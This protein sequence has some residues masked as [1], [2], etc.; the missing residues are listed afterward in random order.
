MIVKCFRPTAKLPEGYKFYVLNRGYNSGRPSYGPNPNCFVIITNTDQ[1]RIEL[2]WA[3]KALY[4][5]GVFK[6]LLVGS[7]IEL[8][9]IKDFTQALTAAHQKL[10]ASKKP[11]LDAVRKVEAIQAYRQHQEETAKKVVAL[12]SSM[13][14][15]IY[16]KS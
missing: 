2:Y 9:R 3:C 7:V 1:E 8:I 13:L 11:L 4:L 15:D 5:N 14:A 12:Q 10:H 16:I 6:R